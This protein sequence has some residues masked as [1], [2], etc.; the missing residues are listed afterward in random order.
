MLDKSNLNRLEKRST[1]ISKELK[2]KTDIAVL[3]EFRFTASDSIRKETSSTHLL[4]EQENFDR[5]ESG[6][7]SAVRNAFLPSIPLVD[8]RYFIL[9]IAYI[10]TMTNSPEQK[11]NKQFLWPAQ[12]DT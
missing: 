8:S 4:L 2:K 5:N 9:I 1:I 3:S 12:P 7:A 6:V 11:K 10:L